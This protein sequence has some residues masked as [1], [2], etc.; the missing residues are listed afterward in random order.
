[1]TPPV[2]TGETDVEALYRDLLFLHAQAPEFR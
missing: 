2:A 1:M